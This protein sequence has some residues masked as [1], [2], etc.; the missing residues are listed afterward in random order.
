M[1]YDPGNVVFLRNSPGMFTVVD[2]D[3]AKNRVCLKGSLPELIEEPEE[4]VVLVS[5]DSFED[6]RGRAISNAPIIEGDIRSVSPYTPEEIE[7]AKSREYIMVRFISDEITLEE[8]K[9][10]M[11]LGSTMVRKLRNAYLVHKSWT[12]FVPKRSGRTKGETQFPTVVEELIQEIA[13]DYTGPGANEQ[14]VIDTIITICH[15]K[16]GDAPSPSTIRRRLRV[17]L[18]ERERV[19][20]KKGHEAA[21][22]EFGSYPYG[23][24]ASAP[25]EIVEA[26]GSPL[27][28]HVRCK[29]TGRVL[30]RPY[31]MLV[32]DKFTKA[33][34]GFALYF[35]A[36]SRWTLAQAIDMA[37]KPKDELLRSLDL[38]E[39]YKWIQYGR[40]SLLLVDGGPTLTQIP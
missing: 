40:M 39:T 36:P 5:D 16:I 2:Y 6:I 25:L 21:A 24:I 20:A 17:I 30:G 12:T 31:L 33:Y 35:G 32:K 18:T 38:D 1:K 14:Q 8:T 3:S 29:H 19:R 34:L 23:M 13:K 15:D 27:D 7:F 10:L 9:V 4:N 22:D 26:D 37:I 28:L 11:G